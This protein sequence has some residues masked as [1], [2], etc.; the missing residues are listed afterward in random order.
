MGNLPPTLF[1]IAETENGN[2]RLRWTGENAC[3]FAEPSG[4]HSLAISREDAV[5]LSNMICAFF[6]YSKPERI[7]PC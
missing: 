1:A 5:A 2:V 3:Y 7:P 6:G 4:I